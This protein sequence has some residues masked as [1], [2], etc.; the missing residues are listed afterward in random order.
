MDKLFSS[1]YIMEIR[2][3]FIRLT[4]SVILAFALLTPG[5]FAS[6]FEVTGVGLKA[7]GMG[8]AFRAIANDWTAA[9]YNPAGY[10]FVYDNQL[11]AN[12]GLMHLRD[13]LV[14]SYR[15]GGVYDA[16]F[17]NDRTIYNHNEIYTMPSGG[18][19][20]RLP[21][22]GETVFG[23]SAYQ[24]FDYSIN[25]TLY[26]TPVAYND[27]TSTYLPSSQYKNN[28]DVVA[29]QLTAAR[30]FMED[31]LAI[32]IGLQVLRGDLLFN[33][34]YLR[35]NPLDSTSYPDVLSDRPYDKIPE[36]TNNNGNGWGF[37]LKAGMLLKVNDKLN[38]GLAFSL[39]FDMT[40]K[41]TT[42]FHFIM[43]K[44]GDLITDRD[45]TGYQ[46]GNIGYLFA[47]GNPVDFMADYETKLKLP[48]SISG[49]IAYQVN[50]KLRVA[51]D[52]EYTFWSRFDGFDFTY[53]GFGKLPLEN[54][55]VVTNFFTYN[56]ANP[57]DWN[58]AGKV[59]VGAQYAYNTNLTFLG[60]I[61]ADQTPSKDG[62]GFMPQFV[63]T[64]DKYG[65][66]AGVL[67][68]I[69]RWEV[70]LV[71]S[72]YLFPDLTIGSANDINQD[73]TADQFPGEYKAATYE[74]ILAFNYW[75]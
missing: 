29:F 73:D 7:R 26:R 17:F 8:G 36:F 4:V 15:L 68:H 69:E 54:M 6:G 25:W 27:S 56:L 30:E 50:E 12:L 32:G 16:G 57:V 20:V 48:P 61:S 75:F 74:T 9:Y 19:L 46:P 53:S 65:F 58:N 39:P 34:L 14:P 43:P 31:K 3:G 11:G 72:Y 66:N 41:G 28:L 67:F 64:G 10:A 51:L 18:F 70:G 33:N 2:M 21:F 71:T 37:G 60:G 49:G 59:M 55:E 23:L 22:W 1:Q 35:T 38:V 47:L 40:L 42:E 5:L 44:N 24:P 45:T 13:E 63:D 62:I 52:A